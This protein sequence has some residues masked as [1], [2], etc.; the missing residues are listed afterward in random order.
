[1]WAVQTLRDAREALATA[2]EGA[3][4]ALEAL[5]SVISEGG[6]EDLRARTQEL[7]DAEDRTAGGAADAML[8]LLLELPEGGG[9]DAISGIIISSPEDTCRKRFT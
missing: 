5:L 6:D 2:E 4:R 8:A 3:R 7:L 1:M 9:V